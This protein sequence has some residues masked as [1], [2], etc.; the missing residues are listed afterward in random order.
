MHHLAGLYRQR[1]RDSAEQL[2]AFLPM[3]LTIGIGAG[4]AAFYAISVFLP[5]VEMLRG[6]SEG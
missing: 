5:L 2:A 4:A 6:L 1:A 3:I